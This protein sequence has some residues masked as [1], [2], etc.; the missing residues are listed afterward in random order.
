MRSSIHIH[1]YRS[2]LHFYQ[3]EGEEGEGEGEE[4]VVKRGYQTWRHN[5]IACYITDMTYNNNNNIY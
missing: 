2:S 4:V 1:N 5:D 3:G